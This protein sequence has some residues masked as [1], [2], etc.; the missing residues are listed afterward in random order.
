MNLANRKLKLTNSHNGSVPAGWDIYAQ[1]GMQLNVTEKSTN[2]TD[3]GCKERPRYLTQI[4]RTKKSVVDRFCGKQINCGVFFLRK[5]VVIVIMALL[6]S[7]TVVIEAQDIP[8]DGIGHWSNSF[9]QARRSSWAFGEKY[10]VEGW[11]VHNGKIMV[12]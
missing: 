10:G 6:Q 7:L 1:E 3:G 5:F 9:V 4:R 2:A 8:G 12:S 11:Q